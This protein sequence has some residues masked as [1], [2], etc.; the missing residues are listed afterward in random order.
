M[1]DATVEKQMTD[2]KPLQDDIAFVRAVAE[3][4]NQ[5]HMPAIYLIWA[6]LCL[7]GFTLVDLVGPGSGW[8]AVYWFTMGPVGTALTWWLSARAARRA[9]QVDR[10]I[11]LRWAGHFVGFFAVGL[12][13]FGLVLSGQ[14][15]WPGLSSLWI[16]ILALTYFLAGLHLER[17]LMPVSL[18]LAAGY[19][20]TLYLPEY[21]FT[22]AGVL[23]AAALVTQAKI[24]GRAQNAGN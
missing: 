11:G 1:I 18:V 6:V 14:M 15:T 24:G 17:Q 20:F 5:Q 9:G 23:V 22:T 19:L 7:C 16:L 21:G 10:R 2:S 13:G 3:R 12:L 4:S 8:I